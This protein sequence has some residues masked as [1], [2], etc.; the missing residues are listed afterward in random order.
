MSN[1]GEVEICLEKVTIASSY[2]SVLIYSM[3]THFLYE[4]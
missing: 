4:M 2:C 1:E 3:E